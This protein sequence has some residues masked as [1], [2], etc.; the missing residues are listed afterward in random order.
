MDG[1]ILNGR[2]KILQCCT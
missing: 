1:G 2:G